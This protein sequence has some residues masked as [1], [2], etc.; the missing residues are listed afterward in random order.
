[1]KEKFS[2]LYSSDYRFKGYVIT[3]LV[4][5]ISIILTISIYFSL[6]QLIPKSLSYSLQIMMIGTI[7]ISFIIIF[8]IQDYLEK[9]IRQ[10]FVSQYLDE[11]LSAGRVV[12]VEL[13]ELISNL[14]PDMVKISES[15]EGR[16]VLLIREPADY[17]MYV[18]LNGMR[19]KVKSKSFQIKDR[20]LEF[21]SDK[22]EGITAANLLGHNEINEDFISLK[23]S[24]VI[25][26]IY[27]QRIFGFLGVSNI[28]SEK[29]ISNLYILASKAAIAVYNHILS[30]QIVL[31][32]KYKREF[33]IANRIEGLIFSAKVPIIKSF[34]FEAY[35]KDPNVLVEFFRND[36]GEW[37]FIL[38][39]LNKARIGTGL[40][41]SH[42]LGKMY[43]QSL[44][45]RKHSLNSI[46]SITEDML[47]KLSWEDGYEMVVGSLR[48]DLSKLTFSQKGVNFR[49]TNDVDTSKSLIS[50][51][52]R[53]T[54]DLKE[55]PVIFIYYKSS[56]IISVQNI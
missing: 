38:L 1:M 30:S 52:W 10:K 22:P 42:L 39:A 9:I 44:L 25:P 48:E 53:Y 33:E 4:R 40:V 26:F 14:F 51:G 43:S 6:H 15:K 8:P 12:N 31:H 56:K 35:Q 28:P 5:L 54:V 24:Y 17:E 41:S 19:R 13:N 18:Y 27:R 47:R 21:L 36:D 50:V 3:N 11:D 49:I 16:M 34:K 7:A 2:F 29:S 32:K 45:R 20:L 55:N 37:L 46:K 23:V